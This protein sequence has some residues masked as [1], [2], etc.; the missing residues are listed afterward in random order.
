MSTTKGRIASWIHSL[1]APTPPPRK[2]KLQLPIA[3]PEFQSVIWA[4]KDTLQ[5]W[6]RILPPP[7]LP[8]EQEII[9]FINTRLQV[10]AEM[11]RKT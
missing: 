8:E 6:L 2:P 4:N 5:R 11:G 1:F 10:M 3:Y 9:L 7:T